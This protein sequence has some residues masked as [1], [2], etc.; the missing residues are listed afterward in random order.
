MNQVQ[1]WS[2][3]YISNDWLL[4]A[5]QWRSQKYLVRSFPSRMCGVIYSVSFSKHKNSEGVSCLERPKGKDMGWCDISGLPPSEIHNSWDEARLKQELRTWMPA[6]QVL[7]LSP[8][9]A[10]LY[11]SCKLESE[12]V[13]KRKPRYS[14]IGC[15]HS[16]KL[17]NCRAKCQLHKIPGGSVCGLRCLHLPRDHRGKIQLAFEFRSSNP[18]ERRSHTQWKRWVIHIQRVLL[19]NHSS[20][21][22]YTLLL[23]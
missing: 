21:Y 14:N 13:L 7:W 9:S 6:S 11:I 16:K 19:L 10:N 17:L 23:L 15:G 4:S 22:L 20:S 12:A 8:L 18:D 3:K 5:W 2:M 1:P